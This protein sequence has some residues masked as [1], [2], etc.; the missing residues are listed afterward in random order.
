MKKCFSWRLF[1]FQCIYPRT[2]ESFI[3]R[4]NLS[5]N[6]IPEWPHVFGKHL[7]A[8]STKTENL[9]N[10]HD[11][12]SPHPTQS[13]SC[14]YRWHVYI[15]QGIQWMDPL[16]SIRPYWRKRTPEFQWLN[17]TVYCLFMWRVPHTSHSQNLQYKFIEAQVLFSFTSSNHHL[18]RRFTWGGQDR[19]LQGRI[20]WL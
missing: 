13:Y 14:S 4:I 2:P 3:S 9:Q 1:F 6:S 16:R 17:A 12:R 19:I 18:Q 5:L 7:L 15:S 20:L 11:L 8:C 10:G